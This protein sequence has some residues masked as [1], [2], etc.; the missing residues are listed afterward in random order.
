MI[1]EK[2]LES[3]RRFLNIGAAGWRKI[4]AEGLL[5]LATAIWGSTFLIVQNSIKVIEPYSFIALRFGVGALALAI[6][7]HRKLFHITKAEL[8]GGALIGLF[9]FGGYVLQTLGLQYTTSS[10]AGF[11]TGLNAVFVPFLSIWILRQWPTWG[12]ILG[13]TMA[14]AGLGLLSMGDK[15][16]LN[17]GLGELM[18]LGCAV[19]FTWQVVLVSRFA[20]GRNAFNLAIVQ[21][22]TTALLSGIAGLIAG[23]PLAVPPVTSWGAVLFMGVVA[24]AFTFAVMNRVQ[25]FTSSTRAALIYALEPVFA[26]LFGL[27]AGE[28]MTVPAWIGCVLILGGMISAEARFK[29]SKKEAQPAPEEELTTV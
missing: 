19:C 25:Q 2:E 8:A 12:A 16:D 29:R 13:V 9:L 7:F 5:V 10:K 24:T 27:L 1:I 4:Q 14:T 18:V 6:I 28:M 11:I 22:A 3:G 23:E 15:F 26:G 17:F 20:P 21:I